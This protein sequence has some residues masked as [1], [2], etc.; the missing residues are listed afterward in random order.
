MPRAQQSPQDTA[1][2]NDRHLAAEVDERLTRDRPRDVCDVLSARTAVEGD[3]A[4]ALRVW[5][6]ANAAR[7]LVAEPGRVA[8]VEE[9]LSDTSALL[10]VIANTREWWACRGGGV[11]EQDG[12]GPTSLA[13][14][15]LDGGVDRTHGVKGS[16]VVYSVRCISR[17]APRL[18]E[19]S[20]WTRVSNERAHSLYS[21]MAT[22]GLRRQTP[23]GGR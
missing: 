9:K 22:C 17:C 18:G 20:L 21:R 5:R 23:A 15:H 1:C 12:A 14:A 16:A 8:R 19:V 13:R 6:S 10:G 4:Q 11:R 2:R 7:G 3:Q